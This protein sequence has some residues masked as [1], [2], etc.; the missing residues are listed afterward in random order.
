MMVWLELKQLETNG[1]MVWLELKQLET[2]GMV[3]WLE[4]RLLET[5]GM[6]VWLKP[7]KK[8]PN[9][10]SGQVLLF[11]FTYDFSDDPGDAGRHHVFV[12]ETLLILPFAYLNNLYLCFV[13]GLG[14]AGRYKLRVSLL[15][16][17]LFQM[18]SKFTSRRLIN[19]LPN[20]Q[21]YIHHQF[22]QHL[23]P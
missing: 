20:F 6:V 2:N 18:S 16:Q 1:M 19:L 11:H 10:F 9:H 13:D 12:H 8:E 23:R 21:Q 15:F 14:D 17:N 4:L 5:N 22:L 3:V 7:T